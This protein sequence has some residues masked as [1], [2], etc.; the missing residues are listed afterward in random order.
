MKNKEES[1]YYTQ[2]D[3]I[4]S[5]IQDGCDTDKSIL[6]RNFKIIKEK[7]LKKQGTIKIVDQFDFYILKV[8]LYEMTQPYLRKYYEVVKRPIT[9]NDMNEFVVR[10]E[11]CINKIPEEYK[12]RMRK[13]V[14]N[15]NPF[16]DIMVSLFE[17]EDVC[18]KKD[19]IFMYADTV[20]YLNMLCKEL[21][22]LLS[23]KDKESKTSKITSGIHEYSYKSDEIINVTEF[24][25]IVFE[26][27]TPLD[28]LPALEEDIN[29][30]WKKVS[31]IL[32]L[33]KEDFLTKT[34]KGIEDKR[35]QAFDARLLDF[36]IYVMEIIKDEYFS[37]KV[38]TL[39]KRGSGV[40]LKS[41]RKYYERL[42]KEANEIDDIKVRLH[43]IEIADYLTRNSY[44]EA[45]YKM[46]D[47]IIKCFEGYKTNGNIALQDVANVI[48]RYTEKINC[49]S[50]E[51]V[52]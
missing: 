24:K 49:N 50:K 52:D 4:D 3:V 48:V 19:V 15:F 42:V 10:M 28:D 6:R 1:T 22:L 41:T 16:H 2:N 51:V 5:L 13:I 37:G 8:L 12:D 25:Q 40:D 32:K 9:M 36:M 35:I 18:T 21:S 33:T 11:D 38:N 47:Y 17:L 46:N 43:A 39:R 44:I 14:N 30:R 7:I 29:R 20:K 26:I 23:I 27:E 34:E 31:K 45:M